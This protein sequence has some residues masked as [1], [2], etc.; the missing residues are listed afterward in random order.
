M[1]RVKIT[2]KEVDALIEIGGQKT[3]DVMMKAMRKAIAELQADCSRWWG[4]IT[5]KYDLDKK[6][7]YSLNY[8][9]NEVSEIEK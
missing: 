9:L 4:D 2:Q 1:K 7:T 5:K 6:K 8:M 3:A